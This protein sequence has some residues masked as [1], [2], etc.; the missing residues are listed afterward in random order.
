MFYSTFANVLTCKCI[1]TMNTAM[2]SDIRAFHS[3]STGGSTIHSTWLYLANRPRPTRTCSEWKLLSYLRDAVC[4][5]GSGSQRMPQSRSCCSRPARIACSHHRYRRLWVNW[6][7]G[8]H[9][10]SLRYR[11]NEGSM[12]SA[13]HDP[14]IGVWGRSSLSWK[15]YKIDPCRRAGTKNKLGQT[16]RHWRH[17]DRNAEG[18]ETETPNAS[19]GTGMGREC[20]PPHPTRGLRSV[21]TPRAG[22]GAEPRCRTNLVHSDALRGSVAGA[23][24]PSPSEPIIGVWRRSPH[25]VQGQSPW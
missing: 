3:Q 13:E 9:L 24:G 15:Q 21:V 14:I 12:A 22:C 18:V 20:T 10:S 8:C 6:R 25:G 7:W 4:T 16:N 11:D 17:R 1:D 2:Q 19:R 23:E 5:Y